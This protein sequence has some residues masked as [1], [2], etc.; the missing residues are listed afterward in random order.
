[1]VILGESAVLF[2]KVFLLTCNYIIAPA[3]VRIRR[4]FY[5]RENMDFLT[6]LPQFF[7]QFLQPEQ[8]AMLGKMCLALL[9][10]GIIGLERELKRKPVGIKTCIIIA[11]TT[12]ALTMVSI[13]SAEYYAEISDNIRTDPMRLA[14]QVVSGIGF[15]GAG[16][17]LRK[18]NDA[19]SG[20]TTAAIIWAAAGV[21]IATGAGF[22]FEAIAA[23]ITV[24]IAIRISPLFHRV[25]RKRRPELQQVKLVVHLDNVNAI[26]AISDFLTEQHFVYASS[27]KDLYNGEVKLNIKLTAEQGQNIY[28]TYISLRKLPHVLG[29]DMDS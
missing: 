7:S 20:L 14:A 4:S 22:F 19:I 10:G 21:G 13:Q 26:Q 27:I 23:A 17:I 2:S 3:S 16:V 6:N 8:L 9:L 29:I 18:N 1:M 12:C 24:L 28:D 15:L 5:K 25:M 11:T